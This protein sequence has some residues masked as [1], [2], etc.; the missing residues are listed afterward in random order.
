MRIV[1]QLFLL[2][3]GGRLLHSHK[4]HARSCEKDGRVNG[5][6]QNTLLCCAR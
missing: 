6:T 1:G 2:I 3:T 4:S 5:Y